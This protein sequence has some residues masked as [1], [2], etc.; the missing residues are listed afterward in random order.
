MAAGVYEKKMYSSSLSLHYVLPF[1][2]TSSFGVRC[3]IYSYSVLC[4]MDSA[5]LF[6]ELKLLLPTSR[7]RTEACVSCAR[8]VGARV[9]DAR[10]GS[11]D[12]VVVVAT[13]RMERSGGSVGFPGLRTTTLTTVTVFLFSSLPRDKYPPTSLLLRN[14]RPE[15]NAHF[16]NS[17]SLNTPRPHDATLFPFVLAILASFLALKATP[18]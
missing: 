5:R 12:R 14:S 7:T 9:M 1:L 8:A 11:G 17:L 10:A 18:F 6:R 3:R 16:L 15:D 13:E 2:D 4:Y